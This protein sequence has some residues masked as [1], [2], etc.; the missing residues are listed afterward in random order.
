MKVI[1]VF[2]VGTRDLV[3]RR[4]S[5]DGIR[6]SRYDAVNIDPSEIAELHSDRGRALRLMLTGHRSKTARLYEA[7]LGDSNQPVAACFLYPTASLPQS[8]YSSTLR[9]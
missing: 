9:K 4:V 2:R 7:A 3:V 6:R 1:A 8:I 5:A